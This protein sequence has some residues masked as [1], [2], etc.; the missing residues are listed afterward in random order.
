MPLQ[1]W[2][3]ETGHLTECVCGSEDGWLK[4]V[5]GSRSPCSI[6]WNNHGENVELFSNFSSFVVTGIISGNPFRARLE[7]KTESCFP[8]KEA[9]SKHRILPLPSSLRLS[10]SSKDRALRSEVHIWLAKIHSIQKQEQP[11]VMCFLISMPGRAHFST[12]DRRSVSCGC[13]GPRSSAHQG[14]SFLEGLIFPDCSL[15]LC[16]ET[17]PGLFSSDPCWL[18]FNTSD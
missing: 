11:L 6:L 16:R 2:V 18:T 10:V 13:L 3:P 14:F 12:V 4:L 5:P 9:Q 15:S 17:E 8:Q 1:D 7:F